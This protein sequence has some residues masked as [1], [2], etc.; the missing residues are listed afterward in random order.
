MKPLGKP[1][2]NWWIPW[3]NYHFTTI[4]LPLN[5]H[6]KQILTTG[7][8]RLISTN[9]STRSWINSRCHWSPAVFQAAMAADFIEDLPEVMGSVVKMVRSTDGESTLGTDRNCGENWWFVEIDGSWGVKDGVWLLVITGL[10]CLIDGNGWLYNDAPN[11]W[12]NGELIVILCYFV[13]EF[14]MVVS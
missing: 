3:L 1:V 13:I 5:H 6:S 4:Y 7:S 14:W 10:W 12:P 8:S 9:G 11:Q 2:Q